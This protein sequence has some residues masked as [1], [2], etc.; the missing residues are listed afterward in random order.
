MAV[1]FSILTMLKWL[2]GGLVMTVKSV[3]MTVPTTSAGDA[4]IILGVW[5]AYLAQR[6][7]TN[8]KIASDA[9][10]TQATSS[11]SLC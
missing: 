2:L 3:T 1:P 8:K 6:D 4:A 10:E 9:V 7:Y 5:L 11:A